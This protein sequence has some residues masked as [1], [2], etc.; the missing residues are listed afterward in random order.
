M[1]E[2]KIKT[3]LTKKISFYKYK[4]KQLD[5]ELQDELDQSKQNQAAEIKKKQAL[6]IKISNLE[7]EQLNLDPE[8]EAKLEK[9][10]HNL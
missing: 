7:T 9:I 3:F 10:Q 6:Q 4:T 1:N 5:L 8:S 2:L